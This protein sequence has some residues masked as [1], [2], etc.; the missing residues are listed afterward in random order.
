MLVSKLKIQFAESL[1]DEFPETE[2]ESFFYILT[3]Y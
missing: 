2:I 1:K 3:E